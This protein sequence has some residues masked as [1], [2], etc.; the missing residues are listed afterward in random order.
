MKKKMMQS[1][2]LLTCLLFT[3]LT[4]FS[5]IGNAVVDGVSGT[6]F[7]LT[8]REGYVSTPDGDN[9]LVWGYALNDGLMQYPGPTLMVNQG[10]VITVNLSNELEQPVSILFPGQQGV[11]A[12]GGSDGLL[13]KE[14][15]G[16]SDTVSYTF[17]AGN[18][19]TYMYQ[20]GTR[21]ELQVEMGLMGALIVRPPVAN[22][23]Y[24]HADTAYDHE[25]LFF[26]TE[27]DPN[28][29]FMVDTNRAHLIDNSDYH[30]VLWFIN[31]RNFPD[32]MTDANNPMLPYQP[33]NSV[34]RVHPGETALLRVIS[35]SRDAHPFH[36][37]GN[38]LKLIARDGRLLES[39]TGMG[40]DLS[41]EDF[42][43]TV[44][45]GATFDALW[46]WTGEKMGWDI[47]GTGP[48]FAHDC[49]DGNAD[50]FDD[51]THEYCPDHGKP[52]PVNLPSLQ[53][54]AFGGFYSGSPFLNASGSLPPGEGGLNLNGGMFY[55]W[56]SHNERE[57]V[58]NDIFPGGMM[59]MMIV[60]PHGASIP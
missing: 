49:I 32:I 57:I 12:S 19:G 27:M 56:H 23:A 1:K 26:L 5:S 58:N 38:H 47:Y 14:S 30:P 7:N 44:V 20:S 35:A 3:M 29:H 17:V 15:T 10:D 13:T 8:A 33:Y 37:H 45:P 39:S 36:T 22:Q 51:T 2:S 50:D 54:L 52:I 34:P 9:I 55:M 53:E 42:T 43:L 25:Y 11:T 16:P 28:V 4:G 59:T 41:R 18:A 6:T 60:E 48:E 21:P 24:G 46:T 40:A 31:G